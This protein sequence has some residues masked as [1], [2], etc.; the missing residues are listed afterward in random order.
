MI[1]GAQDYWLVGCRNLFK[2]D[3][4]ADDSWI[5]FG[6]IQSVALAQNV[7]KVSLRDP[8]GGVKRIVAE[9]IT[10]KSES[11]TYTCSNFSPDLL[12]LVFGA[13]MPETW[14][15]AASAPSA[16]GHVC[17]VGKL[18]KIHDANGVNLFNLSEVV[19]C[20]D[21]H[22][23][24]TINVG[25]KT[26]TFTSV[27][28]SAT[29]TAGKKIRVSGNSILAGNKSYTIATYNWSVGTSTVVVV[30]AVEP[31]T[32]AVAP[33]LGNI[34]CELEVNTDYVITDLTRGLFRAVDG[35][36][37]SDDVTVYVA[38]KLGVVS[39][40]KRLIYPQTQA[41][42]IQGTLISEFGRDGFGALSYREMV[43]SLA[44]TGTNFSAD[45]FSSHTLEATVLADSN[46]LVSPAGRLLQAVGALPA[47][48]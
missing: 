19:I 3:G 20:L 2:R 24:T 13:G 48:S 22:A 44:P 25:T 21:N 30:E 17:K 47:Q 33:G 41:G 5:D 35:G 18:H 15:Q 43:V 23:I 7:T 40:G 46:N 8:A 39:S 10:E 28:L 31:T 4:A 27:D 1:R 14:S 29:W 16:V 36:A 9:S 42:V 11:Y 12:A 45:E 26:F 32:D 37:I 34:G 38:Y 6:T